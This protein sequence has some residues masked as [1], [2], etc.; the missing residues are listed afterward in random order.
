MSSRHTLICFVSS[1]SKDASMQ[2]FQSDLDGMGTFSGTQTNVAPTCYAIER[3]RRRVYGNNALAS[4][5][6]VLDQIIAVRTTGVRGSNYDGYMQE[7]KAYCTSKGMLFPEFVDIEIGD[8][9]T[10]A[11]ILDKVLN[12]LDKDT[13]VI[14]ETTGGLRPTITAFSLL[15]RILQT[16]GTKIEF[17]TYANMNTLTVG[18]TDDH[19][20]Y[21]LL[22][23]ASTFADTGN[24]KELN[25]IRNQLGIADIPIFKAMRQF[26]SSVLVCNIRTLED[27]IRALHNAF[28]MLKTDT[29]IAVTAN[30]IIFKHILLEMIEYKMCFVN[31]KHPL[32][33]VVQW[34][35]NNGYLQQA[36]TIL[37]EKLLKNS[38][39]KHCGISRK[40]YQT[41]RCLRNGINHAAGQTFADDQSIPL[42]IRQ[43][44]IEKVDK[45]LNNPSEGGNADLN[46]IKGAIESALVKIRKSL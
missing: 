24:E 25:N 34:C 30:G 14:I 6:P 17:S 36:V 5:S 1:T 42:D 4:I 28:N 12:K 20:M 38:N 7:I 31:S 27:N 23:A 33:D 3:L 26:R 15:A 32:I 44:V 41:I 9:A 39:Y 21:T 10:H 22:E 18:I 46:A 19:Q 11:Q 35:A 40:S 8:T 43:E 45:M 37:Y 13:S 29:S 2:T 16:K